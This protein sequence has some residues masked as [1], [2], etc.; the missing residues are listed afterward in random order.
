MIFS[1]IVSW[2]IGPQKI[3]NNNL[4]LSLYIMKLY[5]L[6]FEWNKNLKEDLFLV[7]LIVLI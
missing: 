6:E 3:P 1:I 4:I 7:I 2:K 5:L